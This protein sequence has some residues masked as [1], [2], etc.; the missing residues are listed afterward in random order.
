V[1]E[2]MLYTGTTGTIAALIEQCKFPENSFLLLEQLPR[3]VVEDDKR[4]DLLWFTRLGPKID[5]SK[6]APATSGRI[7]HP[8]FELRWERE[9]TAT[10]FVYLGEQRVMPGLEDTPPV[11]FTSAGEKRYYL[12]GTL[13]AAKDLEDMDIPP[14][15]PGETYY[16]EVR[17]PRLLRYPIAS[18]ARVQVVVGEYHSSERGQLFRFLDVEPGV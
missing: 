17:I 16:A 13:L 15:N 7:F 9:E 14:A 6:I 12:F 2:E 1:T 8:T 10:R 3:Q 18:P 11:L 5:K 4:Q